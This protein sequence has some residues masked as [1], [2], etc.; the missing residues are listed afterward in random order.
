MGADRRGE[1]CYGGFHPCRYISRALSFTAE[2]RATV[3]PQPVPVMKRF[4]FPLGLIAFTLACS[5]ATS[6]DR[7]AAL[8]L[9]D[10]TVAA[11][12]GEKPPPPVDAAIAVTITTTPATAIFTGVFFN[13]GSIHEDGVGVIETFDGTAWLRF[14]NK[15]PD[16]VVGFLSAGTSANARF[17]VHDGYPP[18][19]SGTLT[20][21]GVDY[22]IDQV[23]S[24]VRFAGC[25]LFEGEPSPCA[26]IE[27]TVTDPEGNP[28]GGHLIAFEKSECLVTDPKR[29]LS[30]DCPLPPIPD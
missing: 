6:A 20:V 16:A 4:A 2:L 28:H 29:G 23:I 1:V 11:V 25:G 22:K 19:G 9:K 24:F 21:G 7:Q 27:F 17:M 13:N 10:P 12:V 18:T 30:Y 8:T 14:D 26:Q 3:P 5:D 15:Q